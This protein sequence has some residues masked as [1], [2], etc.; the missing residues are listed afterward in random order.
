MS[1]LTTGRAIRRDWLR[2]LLTVEGDQT[3]S[4]VFDHPLLCRWSRLDI[5]LALEDL[6]QAGA[7]FVSLPAT[8]ATT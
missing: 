8:G 6:R 3:V 1:P 5:A 2:A 7:I 4:D